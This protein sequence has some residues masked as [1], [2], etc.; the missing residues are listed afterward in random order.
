VHFS[1]SETQ[2]DKPMLSKCVSLQDYWVF[3]HFPSSGILKVT[4]FWKLD[5][6]PSSGERL[7]DTYSV[8]SL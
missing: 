6:F 1:S 2:N 8:A 7:G 4:E 5:L 3:E